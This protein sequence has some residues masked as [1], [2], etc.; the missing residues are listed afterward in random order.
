M[1]NKHSQPPCI[2]QVKIEGYLGSQWA[3]WFDGIAITYEGEDITVLTGAIVDQSA[4][5]GLLK[6]VRNL[7][8]ALISLQ[9]LDE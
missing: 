1:S 6:K 4:L 3:D 7:G 2:Y 5:Y 8:M 9:R